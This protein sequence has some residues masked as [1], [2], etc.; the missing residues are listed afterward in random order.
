M[1]MMDQHSQSLQ[2][3]MTTDVTSLPPSATVLEAAKVMKELNIGAIPICDGRRLMGMLTDRDIV[4]RL[5][6]EQRDLSEQ[7]RTIMTGQVDYCYE[8]QDADEAVHIMQD[9]QIRRLPIVNRE[10]E[11][12]GIV[13]LG[14]LAVKSDTGASGEALEQIS[15][16]AKPMSK[17]I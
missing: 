7:V 5:V 6:A 2:G 13:S 14:D 16:P 17:A 8:D 11:L 12:I 1:T 10:R 9:R 3:V 15:Q 4:V